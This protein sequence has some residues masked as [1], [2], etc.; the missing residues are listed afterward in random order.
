MPRSCSGTRILIVEDRD[1][2]QAIAVAILSRLGC[3]VT[4]AQT[5]RAALT[6]I[7]SDGAVDVLFA[8]IRLPGGMSGLELGQMVR[9]RWPEIRILLTSGEPGVDDVRGA[10]RADAFAVIGKP[11]RA[12]QLADALRQVLDSPVAPVSLSKTA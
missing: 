9:D 12:A 3:H 11:Y 2:V 6:V 5:A 1:D 8:D 10:A 7:E 4:V